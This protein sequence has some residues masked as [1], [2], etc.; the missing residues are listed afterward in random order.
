ML[1]L[2]LWI[3]LRLIRFKSESKMRKSL[4]SFLSSS[5]VINIRTDTKTFLE[6]VQNNG[7]E[8]VEGERLFWKMPRG[9]LRVFRALNEHC[10]HPWRASPSSFYPVSLLKYRINSIGVINLRDLALPGLL[11]HHTT[12]RVSLH[13]GVS[14]SVQK[15]SVWWSLIYRFLASFFRWWASP[16]LCLCF[17]VFSYVVF[18]QIES[19][20]FS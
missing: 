19:F 8:Q 20:W 12:C 14:F 7:G 6:S 2:I 13:S 16:C 17:Q 1:N 3:P 11:K 15:H 10:L 9:N 4:R 18:Q 5:E